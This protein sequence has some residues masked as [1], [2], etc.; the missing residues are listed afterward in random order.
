MVIKTIPTVK[1]LGI[2]LPSVEN[3]DRSARPVHGMEWKE[4]A[5][6]YA[7]FLRAAPPWYEKFYV[8]FTVSVTERYVEFFIST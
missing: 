1:Y 7:R 2:L 3:T 8:V 4:L 6:Q 5:Q